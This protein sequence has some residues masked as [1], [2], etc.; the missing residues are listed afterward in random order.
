MKRLIPTVLLAIAT[1]LSGCKLITHI[2][3]GT[4]LREAPFDVIIV[5][6]FPYYEEQEKVNFIHRLR[7]LWAY[8]LIET[9]V[10]ENVMFSG[11]AVHTPYIESEIMSQYASSL[12]VP[13]EKIYVEDMAEHSTEN[14]FYGYALARKLGFENIAVA[15]DPFQAQLIKRNT[16]QDELHVN[17]IPAKAAW[18]MRKYKDVDLVLN[19]A[20][21]AY[22][23]DFTPL[24]ERISKKERKLGTAGER[25][26]KRYNLH[27]VTEADL[28]RIDF[29]EQE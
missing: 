14:L 20:C 23:D 22:E 29:T 15:T 28:A 16:E 19:D 4:A 10:A 27:K 25:F 2:Q 9:G 12:G 8:H 5:P 17:Y 6:G 3:Y 7:I 18:V 26:R 1:M 13:D 21:L 11:G 24:A